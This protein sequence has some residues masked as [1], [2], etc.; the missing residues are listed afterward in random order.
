VVS[1][2]HLTGELYLEGE[3]DTYQ[4]GLA[5]DFLAAQALNPAESQELIVQTARQVSP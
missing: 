2:E 3:A 5:F 1:T 4:Y